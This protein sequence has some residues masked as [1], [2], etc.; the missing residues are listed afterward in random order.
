M[1]ASVIASIGFCATTW[2]S[3]LF[4][5]T[6][7]KFDIH[8]LDGLTGRAVRMYAECKNLNGDYVKTNLDLN[9]CLGWGPDCEFTPY[10]KYGPELPSQ[11]QS[12]WTPSSSKCPEWT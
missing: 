1:K 4:N 9:T 12:A 5:A 11:A 7:H 8:D 3:S 6:C 2:A 10:D